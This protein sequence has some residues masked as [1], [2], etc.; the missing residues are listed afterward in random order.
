ML[1]E[2]MSDAEY[3]SRPEI[4]STGARRL[5]ESPAK[6]DYWL[7]NKQPGKMDFDIGH[8]VHA[9]VLGVGSPFIEYPEDHLTPSGNVST[10]AATVS[11]AEE[12]RAKNLVPVAPG[13][14]IKAMTESVLAHPKARELLEAEGQREL[15]VFNT[16]D[17]VPSRARFDALTGTIGVDLKTTRKTANAEGFARESADL[18]YFVQEAWYTETLT[19][20]GIELDDFVF[21]VVEK[22]APY[23]VG[24][25][26]HDVIF[27]DM[28]K[29]GA[30]EARKRYRHGIETGE[31]PGYSQDIEYAAPP[32]WMAMLYDDQFGTEL[33]L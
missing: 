17:G 4:S 14:P 28:G 9:S 12:Q 32:A 10:K 8:A 15:S 20:E 21:I 13:D 2:T 18:G 23:L 29:T 16:V 6:F 24:L 30:A 31:W 33:S 19:V 5:L 3:H 25:N 11:W 26:R 22:T 27:R 1:I 7:R